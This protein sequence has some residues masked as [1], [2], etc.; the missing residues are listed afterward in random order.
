VSEEA[1][2]ANEEREHVECVVSLTGVAV[3]T[4]GLGREKVTLADVARIAS[5]PARQ[6]LR[7]TRRAWITEA[8]A[9]QRLHGPG[10]AISTGGRCVLRVVLSGRAV[11]AG[12]LAFVAGERARHAIRTGDRT[13]HGA[14]SADRAQRAEGLARRILIATDRARVT[15]RLTAERLHR[16]KRTGD[17]LRQSADVGEST[18][19]AVDALSLSVLRLRLSGQARAADVQTGHGGDRTVHAV[20]ALGRV[21]VR[22]GLANGALLAQGETRTARVRA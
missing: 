17:A 21:R 2:D 8:L 1:N 7:V 3:Q 14:G 5:Q 4:D 12:H 13:V 10:R 22:N 15:A 6:D 9:R 18:G 20:E 11:L 19:D 16:A